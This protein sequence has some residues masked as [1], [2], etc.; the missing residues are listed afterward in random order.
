MYSNF[1]DDFACNLVNLGLTNE[2]IYEVLKQLDIA[3]YNYDV[4]EKCTDVVLYNQELPEM[5]KKFLVTRKVEGLSDKTLYN[6][7]RFL[8]IFFFTVKK[9]PEQVDTDDITCFL[10]W[11]KR[12]NPEKEVSD[13]SME[14]VLD[15]LRS[16]FKWMYYRRYIDFNPVAPIRPI[17]YEKKMKEPLTEE[18]LEVVRRCC[19]TV[20]ERA[21]V[22]VFFSTGCRVGELVNLKKSDV[23]WQERT[24]HL[25]GKNKKHR[26]GFLN[27]KSLFALRDYLNSRDDTNEYLFVSDRKPH[28]QMHTCGVQKIIRNISERANLNKPLHPHIFRH[29]TATIMLEKGASLQDIQKILGHEE[30]ETTLKYAKVNLKSV[31]DA[32]KK[33]VC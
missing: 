22:E 4:S 32:H 19:R 23:N 27:V 1:R 2:T 8:E 11:Y 25:F 13:R 29:T 20:K 9:S 10:Y 7:K 12:R 18:E 3:S 28:N 16:F 24:V 26:T 6:Y 5:V 31:H 33:Y 30:I 17:K 14:K 21:I 15:C